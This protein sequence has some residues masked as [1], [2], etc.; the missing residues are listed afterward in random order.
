MLSEGVHSGDAGGLVPDTFRIARE[1]FN[2]IEN[3]ETGEVIDQFQCTLDPEIREEI[4]V[5]ENNIYIYIY[6]YREHQNQ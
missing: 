2:R 3:P 5:K 6:I 1:L 4:Y